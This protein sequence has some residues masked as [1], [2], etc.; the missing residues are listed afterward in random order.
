MLPA[1]RTTK[2]LKREFPPT[3]VAGANRLFHDVQNQA[4]SLA[5][6]GVDQDSVCL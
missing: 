4:G 1:R 6:F 5:Q 2:A 3:V